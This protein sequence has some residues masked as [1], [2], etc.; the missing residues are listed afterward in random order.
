MALQRVREK[1]PT[2][3]PCLVTLPDG[4]EMKLLFDK[5]DTVGHLLRVVRDRWEDSTIQEYDALF[6]LCGSRMCTG[7]TRLQSLDTAAP[8]PVHLHLRQETAFG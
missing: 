7:T 2:R 4:T 8:E 3:V 5:G 1:Y 6:V